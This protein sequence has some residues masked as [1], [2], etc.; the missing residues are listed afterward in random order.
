[1]MLA[2]LRLRRRLALLAAGVL[3]GRQRDETRAHVDA[4]ARC[5]REYASLGALVRAIEADPVRSAEPE[6]PLS[7]LLGRVERQLDR[8]AVAR[9]GPAV[10]W[11][12]LLPAA[13]AAALALVLL[14]AEL[15]PRLGREPAA[16][17]EVPTA[18][19][20]PAEVLDRLDR[21]MAREHTARYLGEAQD[22]LLAVA[23][24]ETDC[25]REEDRVD[26]GEAPDRSRKLLARRALLVESRPDAVAS[27]RAVLD[28]VELALR[29][30]ADLPS[31]VRRRDLERLRQ[32]ID[33][34]QLYMRIRL[35]T[36]ELEG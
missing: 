8:A 33:R 30:V 19:A 27:A 16:P 28:E 22:V 5:R 14:G 36:R 31:C 6:V 25:E 18:A 32:E 12:L 23:A 10:G 2:H 21:N 29:E 3:D 20:L 17:P 35:M 26:V 4:C 34:R 9:P 15:L 1:M 11:R 7:A 24:T 13:A